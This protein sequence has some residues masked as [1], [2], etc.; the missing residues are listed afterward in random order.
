MENLQQSFQTLPEK[1]IHLGHD[2]SSWRQT[3]KKGV[4]LII[5][6]KPVI[7]PFGQMPKGLEWLIKASPQPDERNKEM[8]SLSC[9]K[10]TWVTSQI[11]AS[12][13]IWRVARSFWPISISIMPYP[14]WWTPWLLHR[15]LFYF[16]LSLLSLDYTFPLKQCPNFSVLDSLYYLYLYSNLFQHLSAL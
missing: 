8:C 15:G 11:F 1:C 5:K 2:H 12:T 4:S 10:G 14:G 6:E 16:A 13:G 7:S 9:C 3:V